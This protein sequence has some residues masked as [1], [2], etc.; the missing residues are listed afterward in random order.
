MA[1][2]YKD[3][4]SAAM[5][6]IAEDERVVFLGYNVK[7]GRAAG[8]LNNIPEDR[9]FEMPLAENLMMGAAI[10]MSLSGY[11]PVVY[12]E[13]MDF[14]LCALDAMVNHLDKLKSLSGGIHKPACIIRC[15]VGNSE[16]PLF[17]GPTHTQ[18]FSSAIR[19]MVTF[20]VRELESATAIDWE[21]H[22][23]LKEAQN[24]KSTMLVDFKDSWNT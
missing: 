6:R 10:G 24:G 16:T 15:V 17:T 11:I 20:P 12:V 21:Y 3:H 23:A 1:L 4:L 22:R 19:E 18:N 14:L 7:Y 13:R 2:T 5:E 8:T 9:L